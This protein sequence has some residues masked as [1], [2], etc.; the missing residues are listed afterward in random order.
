MI[1]FQADHVSPNAPPAKAEVDQFV[2]KGWAT[3]MNRPNAEG[4]AK[5][6]LMFNEALRR[7]PERL[8]ALLGL[9][10]H[11]TW[12]SPLAPPDLR[13][14]YR[15]EARLLLARVI[16][17]RPDWSPPYYYLGM[18]LDM[19][20]EPQAG[21]ESLQKCIALNPSFAPGYAQ[22]G[23]VQTRL[24]QID[25]ALEN[26]NHAMA[27]SPNDPAFPAWLMF[28]GLAEIERGHD[29]VAVELISRAAA[30][31]PNDAFIQASLAS[32][33][34]LSG[35]WRNADVHAARYRELTPELTND[36]RVA[37]FAGRWQPKRFA[38]GARLALASAQ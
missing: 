37:T 2:A 12:A 26:I 23:R 3:L 7:D 16:A 27:L 17:R 34:A 19:A 13:E 14:R 18:L 4:M 9:A 22:I 24:G 20:G 10:A 36:Q 31:N 6:E 15:S 8:G 29:T 32:V 11:H 5:A 25:A 35:D 38:T 1:N 28:A 33:Y 21:L 30:L